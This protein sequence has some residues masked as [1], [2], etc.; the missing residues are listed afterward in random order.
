MK[1]ITKPASRDGTD[2]EVIS[3]HDDQLPQ[4]AKVKMGTLYTQRGTL[5]T[6]R[7]TLYIEAQV[8]PDYSGSVAKLT[9]KIEDIFNSQS[10]VAVRIDDE[11]VGKDLYAECF[12]PDCLQS[13]KAVDLV[14]ADDDDEFI[15]VER[16]TVEIN[17]YKMDGRKTVEIHEDLSLCGEAIH[18]PSARFDGS[19]ERPDLVVFMTN[20]LRFSYRPGHGSSS[21]VNRLI[22][23][24]GP[25]GTGKTSLSTGLA[26]KL[27]VRLNKTFED[28]ILLQLNAA[29]LLSQ[30]F[31]QSAVKI[32]SIF[33]ALAS[34][35]S[36]L[37]KT[38]MVLLIDEIESVAASRETSNA[39]N[40]V[41]DAVRATNAL[42]TGFDMVKN[43][44]NVLIICTSNLCTSLDA[45][46]VDRCSRYIDIP[47]PSSAARYEILRHSING[48]VERQVIQTPTSPLPTFKNA[49]YRLPIDFKT[50][51]CALRRLAENLEANGPDRELVSAR[52]LSQLA[53]IALANGLGPNAVCTV[54]NAVGLMGRYI[55]TNNGR[56]TAGSTGRKRYPT[57]LNQGSDA[58]KK[59]YDTAKKLKCRRSRGPS[60]TDPQV[61]MFGEAYPEEMEEMVDDGIAMLR[62]NA[63]DKT[64]KPSPMEAE[65]IANK[66]SEMWK[67]CGGCKCG[68]T[69]HQ[70]VLEYI[71]HDIRIYRAWYTDIPIERPW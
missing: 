35:S 59:G 56:S 65:K 10:V 43:N 2:F 57:E 7:G 67:N 20:L 48:L 31:G 15:L 13:L 14:G 66:I 4:P 51:G 18:L 60:H 63:A 6:R 49:E 52:W 33:E 55:E 8:K 62:E 9:T 70:R 25:P 37:P 39:R 47:Q 19:W 54:A 36:K 68:A 40:E 30:Y 71:E 11:M 26:Q 21:T 38:L 3:G 29:T 41:H 42:L 23:L 61:H 50:S 17:S 32:N 46:F 22:L 27:A 64:A 53:E 12:F 24:S 45:A 34:Q 16:Y 1:V 69:I 58:E 5:Y 44:A 28:T